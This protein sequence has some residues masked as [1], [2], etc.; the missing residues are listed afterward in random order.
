MQ[1]EEFLDGQSGIMAS[2]SKERRA[3]GILAGNISIYDPHMMHSCRFHFS[4]TF[5]QEK[6]TS[7]GA[8]S[9]ERATKQSKAGIIVSCR[10]VGTRCLSCAEAPRLCL[11]CP[12]CCPFLVSD[13]MQHARLLFSV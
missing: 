12:V 6:S 3:T 10:L 5:L 4:W 9:S 7:V 13:A 2:A 1:R 11:P 8:V